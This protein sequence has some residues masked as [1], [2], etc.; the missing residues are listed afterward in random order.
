MQ[1]TPNVIWIDSREYKLIL[2]ACKFT[3]KEEGKERHIDILKDYF[4]NKNIVIKIDSEFG[5]IRF[6]MI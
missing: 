2:K 1:N 6:R 3:D 4:K 5:G